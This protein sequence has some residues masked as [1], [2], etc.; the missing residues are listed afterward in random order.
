MAA[1]GTGTAA[2]KPGTAPSSSV[3]VVT[4][5][6]KAGTLRATAAPKRSA[7]STSTCALDNTSKQKKKAGGGGG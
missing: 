3:A 2:E 6:G 4:P 1:T 7:A 5:S